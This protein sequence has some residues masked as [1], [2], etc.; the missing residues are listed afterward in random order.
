M[1]WVWREQWRS[2]L[3]GMFW[4]VAWMLALALMPAM[5]GRAIDE[6]LL[7]RSTSGL[8]T[9]AGVVMGLAVFTGVAGGMRHRSALTNWLSAAYIT[10]QVTSR[11][12]VR[13]GDRKSDV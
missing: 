13:V 8:L 1:V 7:R 12:S 10:I 3:T 2:Q 11:H 6:G 9:W 4:G 5:I